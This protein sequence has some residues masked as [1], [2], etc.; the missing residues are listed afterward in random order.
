[1]RLVIIKG[2]KQAVKRKRFRV[3]RKVTL[4]EVGKGT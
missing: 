3:H 1:M 4:C 2:K